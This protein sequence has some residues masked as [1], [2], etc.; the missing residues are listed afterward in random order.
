[1]SRSA[2]DRGLF[3][4]T[5][6]RTFRE[7]NNKNHSTGE[8]ETFCR[9]NPLTTRNMKPYNYGLLQP[10]GFVSEGT[11]VD[12]GDIIIGKCMPQKQGHV[13]V[14][15]DTSVALKSNERGIVIG[16]RCVIRGGPALAPRTAPTVPPGWLAGDGRSGCAAW[17][18]PERRRRC[19]PRERLAPRRHWHR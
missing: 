18:P 8:E 7:Q 16:V 9:P 5:M 17:R 11:F 6:F 1:M 4:T 19:S 14:N 2:V 10:S 3:V 12:S 15:K 13:I